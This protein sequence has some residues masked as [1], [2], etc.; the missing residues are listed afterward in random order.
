[1]DMMRKLVEAEMRLPDLLRDGKPWDSL[2][3]AYHPPFVERLWRQWGDCRICL[4]AIH[5]L[6]EDETREPLFHPHLWPSAM[7][8][9]DSY[10]MDV[11]YGNP[12]DPAPAVILTQT[13][14][15]GS[16]YA[17]EDPWTWHSVRPP[18]K[19]SRSTMV[20]GPLYDSVQRPSPLKKRLEL[21]KSMHGLMI[22]IFQ[23]YYP[24]TLFREHLFP[25]V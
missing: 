23:E 12:D 1:M 19:T 3:I 8:V 18:T 10:T 20:M 22:E 6:D 14:A 9:H 24:R 13:L 7:R 4:H 5:A 25:R 11:G 16:T 21:P 17:M 2:W 15:A